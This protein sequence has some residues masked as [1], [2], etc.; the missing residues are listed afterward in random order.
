MTGATPYAAAAT[1]TTG[2]RP[3]IEGRRAHLLDRFTHAF[4]PG[5]IWCVAGPNG[6]GKTTLLA[7]LAGLQPP[8]GDTSRSTAGACR[9]ASRAPRAAPRADAA[10][11]ARCVQR[12]GV[13]H[14]A[15]QPL[16]VS[17]RLGLGARRRPRGR[18]RCAG[19]V[20]PEPARGARR[21]VAVGRRAAA[22]R[23]GRDA[24]PGCAADAAR[25][26]ARASRPASPDRLP[27][28]ARR[29]GSRQAR[30]RWCFRVTT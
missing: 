23:A 24:V 12:D 18:A 14:G 29:V 13:R 25:R 30:A 28:R 9:V 1:C 17:R 6:A 22:G 21:D 11:I 27:D 19:D 3:D 5:E 10:A 26:T 7:T 2:R 20:R 4:R 15:A 16:S 8:A